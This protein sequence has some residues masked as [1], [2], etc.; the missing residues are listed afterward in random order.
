MKSDATHMGD[1]C[2]LDSCAQCDQVL[3]SVLSYN[4]AGKAL[5]DAKA[6]VKTA[7]KKYKQTTQKHTTHKNKERTKTNTTQHTITNKTQHTTHIV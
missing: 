7:Q 1:Q 2:E 4:S 3:Q 5:S 6:R